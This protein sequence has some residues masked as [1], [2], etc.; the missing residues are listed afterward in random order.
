M[1]N[2]QFFVTELE[3]KELAVEYRCEIRDLCRVCGKKIHVMAFK[4]TGVCCDNHRKI[5]DGDDKSSYPFA[6]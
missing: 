1:E 2:D 5:R 4:G 3:L 6:R